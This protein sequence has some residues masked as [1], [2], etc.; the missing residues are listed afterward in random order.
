MNSSTFD[1]C[2]RLSQ[3]TQAGYLNGLNQEPSFSTAVPKHWQP[4]GSRLSFN[5]F[6][7]GDCAETI[8]FA[9]I[10]ASLES[11]ETHSATAFV[12]QLSQ[13][14]TFLQDP[15][16][17]PSPVF[18]PPCDKCRSLMFQLDGKCLLRSALG[19]IDKARW[20]IE[21]PFS[22]V[23][24]IIP[25]GPQRTLGLTRTQMEHFNSLLMADTERIYEMLD[26]I[27][28]SSDPND[29]TREI[30]TEFIIPYRLVI[31][32][33]SPI[34]PAL[35]QTIVKVIGYTRPM[36][37]ETSL[38]ILQQST[39]VLSLYAPYSVQ[40]PISSLSTLRHG[41]HKQNKRLFRS[42][43]SWLTGARNSPHGT[44]PRW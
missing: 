24:V 43:L 5:M 1:D 9:S 26:S 22:Q 27:T 21:T 25:A 35:I 18:L 39:N 8:P 2:Q 28:A 7:Y 3:R 38:P 15:P 36:T 10:P 31:F 14:K 32:L 13:L 17:Y 37:T 30:Y 23:G 11:V 29:P 44:I 12:S 33:S 16:A 40:L 34:D 6:D 42:W 41:S 4:P 20:R 19:W